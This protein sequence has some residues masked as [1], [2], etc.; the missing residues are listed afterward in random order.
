MNQWEKQFRAHPVHAEMA[1]LEKLVQSSTPPISDQQQI[2]AYNRLVAVV[3]L[4]FGY[5]KGLSPDF[6]SRE[7]LDRLQNAF[8]N[9]RNHLLNYFKTK[10]AGHLT[11]ANSQADQLLTVIPASDRVITQE[12]FAALLNDLQR[13]VQSLVAGLTTTATQYADQDPA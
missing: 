8:A 10:S 2:D 13:N 5:L 9:I 11:N 7:I 1:E 4:A 12:G 6:A 3:S